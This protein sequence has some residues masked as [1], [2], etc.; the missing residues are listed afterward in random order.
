MRGLLYMAVS[1]RARAAD[2]IDAHPAI[3]AGARVRRETRHRCLAT[4]RSSPNATDLSAVEADE[5]PAASLAA[6]Y[7]RA[8]FYPDL[9]LRNDCL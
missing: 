8:A 3:G 5:V 4:T 2:V 7:R 1:R 9:V 6:R